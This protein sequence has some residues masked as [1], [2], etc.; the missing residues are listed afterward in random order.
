MQQLIARDRPLIV[1]EFNAARYAD[2][3]A[4]LDSL[5]AHYGSTVELRPAGDIVPLDRASV[6]D[7]ARYEDRL[8]VFE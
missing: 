7:Q 5:L 3:A 2:P 4:F 6:L 8:L 1:L